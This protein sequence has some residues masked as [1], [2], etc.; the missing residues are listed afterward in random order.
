MKKVFIKFRSPDSFKEWKK[1]WNEGLVGYKFPEEF[2]ALSDCKFHSALMEDNGGSIWEIFNP[3]DGSRVDTARIAITKDELKCI[4]FVEE[5]DFPKEIN[6]VELI[7][8]QLDTLVVE[9]AGLIECEKLT[10]DQF[11]R[12]QKYI[13]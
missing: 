6:K 9:L 4:Q 3:A 2:E 10:F 7:L 5:S 8:D 1:S 11:L 13:S 12:V